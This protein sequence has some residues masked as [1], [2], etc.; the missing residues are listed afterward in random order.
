VTGTVRLRPDATFDAPVALDG[1]GRHVWWGVA[2]HAQVAVEVTRPAPL[3]FSGLGYHDCNFGA[4][5]LEDGFTRWRWARLSAGG[6]ST[7][8]YDGE[9]R[10]GSSF[11]S[12]GCSA[13]TGG[14]P[15]SARRRGGAAGAYALA[16]ASQRS[17]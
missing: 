5:P 2:P 1:R 10:D 14:S 15:G 13:R 6:R 4:E 3:R 11:R 7:V 8:L 9:R 17:L 12:A 16:A